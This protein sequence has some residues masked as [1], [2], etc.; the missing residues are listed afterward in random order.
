VKN[1]SGYLFEDEC[2]S[3]FYGKPLKRIFFLRQIKHYLIRKKKPRLHIY[4][5][6]ALFKNTFHAYLSFLAEFFPFHFRPSGS[7]SR[8]PIECGTP[9][10][11]RNIMKQL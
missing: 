4:V 2:G 3:G 1:G 11:S 6:I 9:K 10:Q 7:G 8:R 5:S